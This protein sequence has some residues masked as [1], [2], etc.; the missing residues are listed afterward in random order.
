[1]V[2]KASEDLPEPL[3]P[4]I[5]VKVLRGISTSIFFRLCWRAPCTLM[6]VSM[7]QGTLPFSQTA[8]KDPRLLG[9]D[10][11]SLPVAA[12]FGPIRGPVDGGFVL[13][14][15]PVDKSLD[16]GGILAEDHQSGDDEDP[17]GHD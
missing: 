4:V 3:R 7:E 6:R 17:A 11:R 2:S 10:V 5:T 1:M 8:L 16:S 12:R 9:R 13:C 14:F 15:G